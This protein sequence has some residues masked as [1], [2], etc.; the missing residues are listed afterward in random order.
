MF[1]DSDVLGLAL[2]FQFLFCLTLV[3][4]SLATDYE[5]EGFGVFFMDSQLVSADSVWQEKFL[6]LDLDFNPNWSLV[7]EGFKYP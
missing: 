2:I 7:D 1:I 5:Q 4:F 6:V 3:E